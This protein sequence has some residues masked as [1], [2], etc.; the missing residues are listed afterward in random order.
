[1]YKSRDE[2]GTSSDWKQYI[3]G[4]LEVGMLVKARTNYQNLSGN[5]SIRKG[6][7]GEIIQ[8]AHGKAQVLWHNGGALSHRID[9]GFFEPAELR[10]ILICRC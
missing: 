4:F 10:V 6:D 8:V 5:V 7:I 1:M 2:F 9:E 3:T